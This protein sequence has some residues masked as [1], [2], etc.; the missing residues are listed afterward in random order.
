MD[1]ST[2]NYQVFA[3]GVITTLQLD[4]I[5]LITSFHMLRI[6]RTETEFCL[7]RKE[8]PVGSIY[9]HHA[10]ALFW[11]SHYLVRHGSCVLLYYIPHSD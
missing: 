3:L 10:F 6:C 9:Q 2:K 1:C 11:C 4:R 5:C 7:M 8:R